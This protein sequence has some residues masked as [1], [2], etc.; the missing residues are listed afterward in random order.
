MR[1]PSAS[2]RSLPRAVSRETARGKLRA[3]VE[4]ARIVRQELSSSDERVSREE[5]VDQ[6]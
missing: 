6:P 3:L 2:A 5:R 1:A 4:G